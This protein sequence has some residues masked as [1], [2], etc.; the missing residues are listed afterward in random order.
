MRP[1]TVIAIVAFGLAV[2]VGYRTSDPSSTPTAKAE[3]KSVLVQATLVQPAQISES[4]PDEVDLQAPTP[5]VVDSIAPQRVLIDLGDGLEPIEVDVRRPRVPMQPEPVGRLVDQYDELATAARGGD[6]ATARMLYAELKICEMHVQRQARASRRATEIFAADEEPSGSEVRCE[7]VSDI[8]LS[9]SL[10][11]A[12]LAAESGDYVGRQY[13]G[14]AL[15]QT[16]EGLAA[17]ESF[18]NDGNASALP[19]IAA[20]YGKGVEGGGPDWVKAY[21]ASLIYFKLSEASQGMA[22]ARGGQ[23]RRFTHQGISDHLHYLSGML[24]PGQQQEAQALAHRLLANNTNCCI[25]SF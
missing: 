20:Y 8:H 16:P 1:Y 5:T 6:G 24:S 21:A 4:L 9:D 3:P 7:G 17:F 18:W 12:E 14:A 25:G 22:Q 2:F 23:V 11:W 10:Y 15:G 13:Y 19:A